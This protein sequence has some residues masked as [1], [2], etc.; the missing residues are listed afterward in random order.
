MKISAVGL[1]LVIVSLF[2]AVG[3]HAETSQPGYV[4]GRAVVSG[5][6]GFGV[7]G[8]YGDKKSPLVAVSGE[9]GLNDVISVGG[10]IG[11]SSSSQHYDYFW[12]TWNVNWTYTVLAVRGSYH[13]SDM[14]E[15]DKV[16][17][18]AGASLGYNMVSINDGRS[19]LLGGSYVLYGLHAGGRY[20][21]TDRVGAFAELGLGLGNLALGVST[22]F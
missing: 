16:D 1:A 22:R 10:V 11:R 3:A 12:S 19:D 21:F 20:F 13:L 18:Y 15:N 8:L 4:P 2:V 14:I 6:L 5:S 7:S 9:Y 17:L